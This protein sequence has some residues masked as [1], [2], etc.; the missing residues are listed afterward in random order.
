MDRGR[1][2]PLLERAGQKIS[3][4]NSGGATRIILSRFGYA[5]GLDA[6][7]APPGREEHFVFNGK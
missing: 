1:A 5:C 3:Q 4:P 6:Q 2:T 7:S